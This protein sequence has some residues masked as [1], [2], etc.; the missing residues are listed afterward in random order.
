MNFFSYYARSLRFC[1]FIFPTNAQYRVR[2]KHATCF[3]RSTWRFL[4]T[5]Y[6]RELKL[7]TEIAKPCSI[8]DLTLAETRCRSLLEVSLQ[9][10]S[11]VSRQPSRRLSRLR[12]PSVFHSVAERFSQRVR[13][14]GTA[15]SI[16][17]I[18]SGTEIRLVRILAARK[19]R[20]CA[21][22]LSE[23]FSGKWTNLL[24][25][26]RVIRRSNTVDEAQPYLPRCLIF[27]RPSVFYHERW[28]SSSRIA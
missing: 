19:G 9:F 10:L 2:L 4:S 21:I 26:R 13:F 11:F 17:H 18:S 20:K 5:K 3:L 15:R 28:F 1:T 7:S 14:G 24:A 22:I 27:Y 6:P 23:R 25:V 8:V 16:I 12:N